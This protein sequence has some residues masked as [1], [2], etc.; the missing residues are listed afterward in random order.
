MKLLLVFFVIVVCMV[1][2]CY[3]NTSTFSSLL[4]TYPA[5]PTVPGTPFFFSFCLCF[6][7]D[8]LL[9]LFALLSLCCFCFFVA[10]PRHSCWR[11]PA[12]ED[13]RK[14]SNRAGT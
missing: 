9:L 2:L 8:F 6:V 14:K 13:E 7:D 11:F 10:S 12:V 3:Y 1:C 4:L 5:V